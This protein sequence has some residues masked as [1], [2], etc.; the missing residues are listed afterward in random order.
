MGLNI[1]VVKL[2]VLYYLSW[3]YLELNLQQ[4]SDERQ[5]AKYL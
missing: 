5:F 3:H 4:K 1:R 2:V